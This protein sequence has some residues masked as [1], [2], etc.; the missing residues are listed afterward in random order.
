MS[1]PM[2]SSSSSSSTRKTLLVIMVVLAVCRSRVVAARAGPAA[3]MIYQF[4]MKSKVDNLQYQLHQD[5]ATAVTSFRHQGV[6]FGFFP[7]G[8]TVPPSAMR[9][10]DCSPWRNSC[11]FA[12]D[13]LNSSKSF[14]NCYEVA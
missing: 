11:D 9:C 2:V 1:S 3:P 10:S 4:P 8:S 13:F 12:N 14:A 6:I 7:K 5:Q